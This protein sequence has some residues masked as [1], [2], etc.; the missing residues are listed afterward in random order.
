MDRILL[1]RDE[2]RLLI[3][4]LYDLQHGTRQD[5]PPPPEMSPRIDALIERLRGLA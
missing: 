2:A 1:D 3:I 4:A 5:D